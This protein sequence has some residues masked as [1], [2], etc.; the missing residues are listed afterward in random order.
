M[1]YALL[2]W[3]YLNSRYDTS[4][5]PML[6]KELSRLIER[7]GADASV[8]EGKFG[9]LDFLC[10]NSEP[11]TDRALQILSSHSHLRLLFEVRPDGAMMPLISAKR[12][13]VG[14]DL[15]SMLKY[16]GKT[17]ELFTRSLISLAA[18]ESDFADGMFTRLALFDPMCGRGTTLFESLNRG[19]NAVASDLD[20]SDVDQGYAYFKRYLEFNRFKH[21]S[22]DFSMTV[23]KTQ[24][25]RRQ[26][27][28]SRSG[29]KMDDGALT[30]SFIASDI[31]NAANAHRPGSFHLVVCDLPYGVQHAPGGDRSLDALLTRA[32]LPLR[33]VLKP[34][35]AIALSFNTYTMKRSRMIELLSGAGFEPL[36]DASYRNLSHWVEQAVLRDFAVAVRRA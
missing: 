24:V 35:G 25:K 7:A 13:E 20:A 28:F 32:L 30:A 8:A 34:G 23:G 6:I 19:W 2:P 4:I 5:R 29:G 12:P 33:R 9:G 22:K 14:G 27:T 26:I 10:F 3:P 16:K 1:Q 31:E 36:D 18:L 21:E 11:L 15:S 17:S